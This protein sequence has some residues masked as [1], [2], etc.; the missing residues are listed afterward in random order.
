MLTGEFRTGWLIR[1]MEYA[2][3]RK[4]E[5]TAVDI[6]VCLKDWSEIFNIFTPILS[7]AK[8]ISIHCVKHKLIF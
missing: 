1:K 6:L 7:D 5:V 2:P 8:V 4:L 3:L